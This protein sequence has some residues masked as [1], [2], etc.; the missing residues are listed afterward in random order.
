MLHEQECLINQMNEAYKEF[1]LELVKLRT[2]KIQLDVEVEFRIKLSQFCIVFKFC[3]EIL[4]I[5]NSFIAQSNITLG[6]TLIFY[7]RREIAVAE[8]G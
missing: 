3:Y 8:I 1:D 5:H 4:I 2:D 6:R 7:T